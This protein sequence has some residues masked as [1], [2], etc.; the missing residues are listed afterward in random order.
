MMLCSLGDRWDL[1]T[2]IIIKL[3]K[4]T[5]AVVAGGVGGGG[6]VWT[7]GVESPLLATSFSSIPE[8]KI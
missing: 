2:L 7:L 3:K 6:G 5:R 1:K 8:L 4:P